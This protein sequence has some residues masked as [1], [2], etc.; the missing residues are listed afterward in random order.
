MPA[1]L[2]ITLPPELPHTLEFT[3]EFGAE[4]NSF[5]PFVHWLHLAGLMRDRHILTYAG[6]APFYFFL[7]PDQVREKS[8]PRRFV[9]PAER[10]PWL[11]T[12]DDHAHR[13]RAF[14]SFPDYRR[15]Y[16]DSSFESAK[17]LL[18]IHNKYSI[19]WERGPV[20]YLSLNLL[21]RLFHELGT[22]YQIVYLRPGILGLPVGY[23][24]DH[25]PDLEFGDL[26]LVRRF[27]DIWLFDELAAEIRPRASYN[28]LKLRLYAHAWCHI[29]VQ[30]GN[31]HLA[32]L[33]SGALLTIFHRFGQEIRLSYRD[34]HFAYAVQP[35]PICL[36]CRTAGQ[37]ADTIPIFQDALL[38]NERLLISPNHASRV[39]TLSPQAQCGPDRML[40]PPQEPDTRTAA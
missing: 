10:P 9:W 38:Q 28:E 25:Q 36:I 26:A 22:R 7:D 12:R 1:T 34:G 16:R 27:P 3:G 37:V 21:E 11:P 39:A 8:G 32:A 35:P 31:A 33:F 15:H 29:T 30:G 19:E 4:V 2:P 13:S 23:S 14:E 20:N 40:P 5:L 18:V 6:M 17:P 24:P